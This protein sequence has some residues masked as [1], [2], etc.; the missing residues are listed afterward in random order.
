MLREILSQ[1]HIRLALAYGTSHNFTGQ[2][3]YET[4]RCYLRD[5]AYE[6]FLKASDL[7][8]NMGY[9]IKV[10][11]A[12][13]PA[14]AQKKL[15]EFCPNPLYVTNPQRGSP[16]TRGIAID[17]TLTDSKGNDVDMG[18]PFDDFTSLSHHRSTEVSPAA[19]RHRFLLLGLMT[20]AGFDFYENEWWHYQLHQASA[21][22]LLEDKDAPFPL[23]RPQAA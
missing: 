1:P 7:A 11:D 20:A 9:G 2:K 23:M 15:W 21:Y 14:E 6:C 19:Q 5:E 8:Q 10:F 12:F 22:P 3:I 16:H 17:L 13:R 4:S 18:T